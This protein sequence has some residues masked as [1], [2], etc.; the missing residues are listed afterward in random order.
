MHG[1]QR[2][3]RED[4]RG[5]LLALAWPASTPAPALQ[6]SHFPDPPSATL[7]QH[8]DPFL[9]LL[10]AP[11]FHAG[12]QPT[13]S[14]VCLTTART[15]AHWRG[16]NNHPLDIEGS[17]ERSTRV[18]RQQLAAHQKTRSARSHTPRTGTR[19]NTD[20]AIRRLGLRCCRSLIVI[21]LRWEAVGMG[22]SCPVRRCGSRRRTAGE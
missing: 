19:R 5:R 4:I 1:H 16:G 15:G 18:R 13:S 11:P 12:P 7:R 3:A 8:G 14:A 22:C 20:R 2:R 6:R 21:P 17:H 9:R 10:L